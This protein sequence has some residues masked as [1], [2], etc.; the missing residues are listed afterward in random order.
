MESVQ[1]ELKFTTNTVEISSGE[2]QPGEVIRVSDALIVFKENYPGNYIKSD[3]PINSITEA[4]RYETVF[5]AWGGKV[6]KIILS[7]NISYFE[8]EDLKQ[9]IFTAFYAGRYLDIFDANRSNGLEGERKG[10]VQFSTFMYSFIIKR[11]LGQIT[12]NT[13]DHCRN[14]VSY[15]APQYG[16]EETATDILFSKIADTG[17]ISQEDSIIWN[18]EFEKAKASLRN[19]FRGKGIVVKKRDS[20]EMAKMERSYE[21]LL[22]L[23]ESGYTKKEI[24][25]IFDYSEASVSLMVKELSSMPEIIRLLSV[26]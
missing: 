6:S 26:F 18:V 1:K 11:V 10:T 8:M 21:N 15:D 7:Y 2:F 13:R 3:K 24:A 25:S 20:G 22:I 16:N 14:A 12:K 9:Q 5:N 17:E 23:L 4:E 19:K